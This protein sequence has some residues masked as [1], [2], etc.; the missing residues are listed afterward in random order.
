MREGVVTG[1]TGVS[2]WLVAALTTLVMTL[3]AA[4]SLLCRFALAGEASS[5]LNPAV[6]TA[7]RAISGAGMLWLMVAR[8]GGNPLRAG[9]W[10]AALAL[11]GYMAC[12]SWASARW[13]LCSIWR[14]ASFSRA[15]VLDRT[16]S[17]A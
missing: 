6:Y 4:N 16:L 17:T 9:S 12:F 1:G 11:F 8:R 15:V 3:F 14:L 13:R 2:L 5:P 10:S 7:L